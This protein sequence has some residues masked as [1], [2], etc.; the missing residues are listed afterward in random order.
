MTPDTI[1]P[2]QADSLPFEQSQRPRLFRIYN[3]YRLVISL[4]LAGLLFVDPATLDTKFRLPEFYEICVLSYLGVNL[5]TGLLLI[6]GVHTRQRHITLSILIDVIALHGLLMLSVGMTGGLANLIIVSVAAGNI[7]TPSRIG[8]FYAALA[9]I[10]SLGVASWSV[11]T[12]GAS[13]D[14]IVRAGSLGVLYFAAAFL[15]QSVTRRMLRSEE[16]ASSRARSLVELEQI[17]KQII[18]RMRTGIVVTDRFGQVRLANA[19]AHELLFGER[20]R[21]SEMKTLPPPLQLRLDQWLNH[22]G[23]RTEPFQATPVAP[24][25]QANFTRLH[26]ERGDQILIFIEDMSKVTLQAQQMKL[27]SLGRLTAGIAHEIRNPLGAISHAAQLLNESPNCDVG[28]RKMVDIIQRHSRRVNGIIENVLDLSRRRQA[29]L[30]LVEI[31]PWLQE[32]VDDYKQGVRN[33]EA[34]P[35]IKLELPPNAPPA[36][37]DK[38]QMAQVMVNLCDNGLRYSEVQTGKPSLRIAVGV[39]VDSERS[40]IDIQDQGPGISPEQHEHIFEPFY[41]TD[42]SGTGLGLYLARELCEANQA[43][44]S[45]LDNNEPGCCFRITFAHHRRLM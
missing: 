33:G 3:H 15:L 8:L 4:I 13:P 32:F 36:R 20:G 24:M 10:C 25:L 23:T 35:D 7:L 9:A 34:T 38:S 29:D 43:H 28:D 30:E 41:T 26:Q 44:L 18:Q 1:P 17:N 31:G 11:V 5:F 37:F 19:A 40:Y 45:L 39:T 6:A 21:R 22:P 14:E 42:Q 16:L 27:A 12:L 2:S